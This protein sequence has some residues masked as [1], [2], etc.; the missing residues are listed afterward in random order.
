M[1]EFIIADL[2]GP[3]YSAPRPCNFFLMAAYETKDVQCT[4]L[5]SVFIG[6][7]K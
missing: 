4:I 5:Q 3:E 6:E 7:E 2:H 1:I